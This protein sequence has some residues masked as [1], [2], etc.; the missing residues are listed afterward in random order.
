MSVDRTASL[1][2]TA[3]CV[4]LALA[5]GSKGSGGGGKKN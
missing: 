2:S 3:A 5:L 1:V 4:A